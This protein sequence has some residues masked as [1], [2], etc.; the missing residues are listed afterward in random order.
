[1]SDANKGFVVVLVASVLELAWVYGL[2]YAHTTPWI[3]L[4]V[5]AICLNFVVL[6]SAFK[7]LPT[8]VAYVVFV[9]LGTFFIVVAELVTL[10]RAGQDLPLGRVGF[11]FL[12]LVGVIGIKRLAK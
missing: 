4:T 2:K 12:L 5:V 7:Y 1:M 6:A 3:A 10:Y 11:I 9:G 8:S